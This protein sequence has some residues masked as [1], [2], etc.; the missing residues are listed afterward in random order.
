MKLSECLVQLIVLHCGGTMSKS[1][2]SEEHSIVLELG[3]A[4]IIV[5]LLII[6]WTLRTYIVMHVHRASSSVLLSD[7]HQ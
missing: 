6:P 1:V 5:A 2:L 7:Y 3:K 4:E